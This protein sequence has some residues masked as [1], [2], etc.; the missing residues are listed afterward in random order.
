LLEEN[1]MTKTPLAELPKIE[2]S[3]PAY[4]IYT[5]GSTGKPKGVVV[6]HGALANFLLSMAETPGFTEADRLLAVTTVSFDISTL[7]ILLPLVTG[8]SLELVSTTIT[9]DG[10]SLLEIINTSG[11]TVMQATPATWRLLLDAG[12]QGSTNLHRDHRLVHPVAGPSKPGPHPHWLAH[13]Q[14]GRP[15]PLR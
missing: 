15:H 9:S 14:Y 12:W 8:G 4:V 5:S 6:S 10:H 11:A 13:R 2:A 1:L 3:D 7:E